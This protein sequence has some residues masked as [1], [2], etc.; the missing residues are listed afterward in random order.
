MSTLGPS[1]YRRL[2]ATADTNAALVKAA[3]GRLRSVRGYNAAASVRY[4]KIYD[5]VVAP[6]VGTDTPVK[7]L[8]VA[9][10]LPFTFDYG[11]DGPWFPTGIAIAMTT[12]SAD[13]NTGALT[14]NDIVGLDIMY[15]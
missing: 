2:T 6:V 4:I 9:P 13:S 8:A 5:S 10:L 14:V 3:P 1:T 7:T 15:R 12:G 11:A